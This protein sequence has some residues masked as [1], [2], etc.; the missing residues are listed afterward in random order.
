MLPSATGLDFD[1][2]HQLQADLSSA[3]GATINELRKA[4]ALQQW[5]ELMARAGSRY[6]EQIYA[7]FGERI[8]DYT[9]QIP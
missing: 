8:P 5:L 9:V 1:N 6:R 3:T 7:I 2:S 4:S